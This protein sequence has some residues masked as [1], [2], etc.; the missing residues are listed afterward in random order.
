MA[1]GK[2]PRPRK[3]GGKCTFW[4]M[5]QVRAVQAAIERGE[6]DGV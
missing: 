2:L 1:E 5:S 3:I 6:F 4:T